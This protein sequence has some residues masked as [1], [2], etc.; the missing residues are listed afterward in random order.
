MNVLQYADDTCLIAD[1]PASCQR[2]LGKVESWLEWMGMRADML[3]YHSLAIKA[4]SGKKYDPRLQ[5]SG[6]DIPF[7][8]DHTI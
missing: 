3:K 8:G 7:I 1:G 4:S 2:M 6:K 5:L